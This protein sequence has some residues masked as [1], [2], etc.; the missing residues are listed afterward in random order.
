MSKSDVAARAIG[1]GVAI[2]A[3]TAGLAQAQ[4]VGGFYGGLGIVANGGDFVAFGDDE[5]SFAGGPAGS[6]FAG[7]NV[8]SGNLVYG[9]ELALSNGVENGDETPYIGNITSL[10]DLKGRVGTMVG[11]TLFYGSLGYSMGDVERVYEDGT[12]GEVSG[13]N[14]G[15]GF[16][17]AVG[18]KMF[19]GG[20][21]TS[22][23][24]NGGG[25]LN[26]EPGELYMDDV[27]LTTVSVRVGFR[28]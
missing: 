20:D 8:V 12:G 6:L 28:F 24:M 13:M 22:R 11:N 7:Y 19:V 18:E 27:N 3:G 26:G 25:T 17:S 10:I 23:H 9:A 5:Y 14:F 2:L 4:D 21:I 15:A 1:G 16:E